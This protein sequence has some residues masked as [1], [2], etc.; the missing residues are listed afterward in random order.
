MSR[1]SGSVGGLGGRP[2]RSTRP[3]ADRG[4]MELA[5]PA[6]E[7]PFVGIVRKAEGL[8]VQARIMVRGIP[9]LAYAVRERPR[10]NVD[11]V[12]LAALGLQLGRR[13]QELKDPKPGEDEDV[14]TGTR[15][16]RL[17]ELWRRLLVHAPGSCLAYLTDFGV[18]DRSGRELGG[19]KDWMVIVGE[20][21]YRDGEAELARRHRH[22]TGSEMSRLAAA[23]G[24]RRLV[25]FHLS[26]R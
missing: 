26:G 7:A 3:A 19:L 10:S 21:S 9:C 22:F 11:V 25:L 16:H 15:T 20:A 14:V 6:G 23:V 2:P 12:S 13:I 24:A 1:R 5:H 18:D 17:E 8:T 4:G